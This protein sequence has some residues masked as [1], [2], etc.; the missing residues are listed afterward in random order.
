MCLLVK[1][2]VPQCTRE[3]QAD[4]ADI[5]VQMNRIIEA[6]R[7]TVPEELWPEILAKLD[8]VAEPAQRA[9]ADDDIDEG[10]DPDDDDFD[11]D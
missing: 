4:I 11:D 2:S 5:Y 6:V 8:G 3:G 9:E 7:S 10:F 1:L